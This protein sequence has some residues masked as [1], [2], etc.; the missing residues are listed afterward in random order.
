MS[1]SAVAAA[2]ASQGLGT[3]GWLLLIALVG[4]LLVGGLLVSRSQRRSAWDTEARAL[5]SETRTIAATRLPPVL[6]TT[7]TGRRSL[8]WP[9]VRADLTDA[10]S[11]WNALTDRAS[12]EARQ[13]WSLRVAG[14]LQ[15]L[16]TAV[17]AEN[18]ALATGQDWTMARARVDQ[19]GRAL[20]AILTVQPQPE[21]PPAAEPGPPAFQT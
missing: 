13:N 10:Q 11:R 15:E 18:E 19:A 1:A 5:E 4:A 21:P 9:P 2:G 14:L 17:D 8:V 3:L 16:I 12:G 7:T 20:I 6:S